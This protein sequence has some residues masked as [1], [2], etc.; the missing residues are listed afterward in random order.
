MRQ[1]HAESVKYGSPSPL[2]ANGNG[3]VA[4]VAVKAHLTY[5]MAGS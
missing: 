4:E 3:K 5:P 2:G 1:Y